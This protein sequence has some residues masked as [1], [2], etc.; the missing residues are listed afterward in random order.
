MQNADRI[1]CDLVQDLDRFFRVG[2]IGDTDRDRQAE[3]RIRQRPVDELPGD[4]RFV[5]DDELFP[6]KPG[7]PGGANVNL[8]DG[9]VD[10]ADAD[11]I[12]HSDRPLE[13]DD[14]PRNEIRENLLKPE[15]EAQTD[16]SD[17]PLNV[18]PA[19]AN[20]IERERQADQHDRV[21]DDRHV[22]VAFS[23]SQP[24]E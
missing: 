10:L 22:G 9:A 7:N 19:D 23:R 8:A 24:P 3:H 20:R 21:L 4:E 14:Q 11:R 18:R 2:A 1:F 17:Q 6:V 13:Q 15:A 12:A 16:G 5:R